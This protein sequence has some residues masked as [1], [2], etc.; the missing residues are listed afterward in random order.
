MTIEVLMSAIIFMYLIKTVS[1]KQMRD[2]IFFRNTVNFQS[3]EVVN[4][5]S[6][7]QLQVTENKNRTPHFTG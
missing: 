1:M 2:M 7:P 6:D 5:G 4:R 3:L